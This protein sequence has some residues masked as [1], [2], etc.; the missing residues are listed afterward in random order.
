MRR[1]TVKEAIF[2]R[3]VRIG[4]TTLPFLKKPRRLRWVLV[5]DG[6][7][8]WGVFDLIGNVWEWTSSKVSAYPG[9]HGHSS[10]QHAG[11]GNDQRWLLR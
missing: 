6:K 7:N 10:G 4:K 9:N 5:P 2:I 3:G 11:L 1:A 8:S